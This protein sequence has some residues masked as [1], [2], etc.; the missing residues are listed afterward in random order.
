[1]DAKKK[2]KIM[3]VLLRPVLKDYI[4]GGEKLRAWYPESRPGRIAESWVLSCRPDGT[5]VISGGEYDG[6]ALGEIF[7]Q[8]GKFPLLVK[9]I[10]AAQ[11]LSVQVH[12][13]DGD[14]VPGD[15]APEGK[16]ECWLILEAEPGAELLCGFSRAT[17]PEEVIRRAKD[18]SLPEIL[19]RVPVRTGDFVFI[20][21]GTVHAIGAGITLLEVQQNSDTTYRLF[22][23]GRLDAQGKPRPIHIE[24]AAAVAD[25][26]RWEPASGA[27]CVAKETADY[28]LSTL[29]DCPQFYCARL[30]IRREAR[31]AADFSAADS[32]SATDSSLAADSSSAADSSFATGG[33]SFLS[34]VCI[35]GEG[36]I[37]TDGGI[38]PISAGSSVFFPAGSS[39]TICGECSAVLSCGRNPE[40]TPAHGD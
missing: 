28:S 7:P 32:S 13:R 18:G 12:P 6:L 38:L 22:D 3:P 11:P 31:V 2:T 36:E 24:Q 1:M 14:T 5:S 17:N 4:W 23:Y 40:K 19:N 27:V 10:D 39:G 37:Q 33:D 20:P 29:A 25:C 15:C 21:A 9:F 34:L 16:T 35:S 30:D 8:R 26:S